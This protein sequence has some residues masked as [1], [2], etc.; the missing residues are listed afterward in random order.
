MD[1]AIFN[2]QAVDLRAVIDHCR[3]EEN[4]RAVHI[5]VNGERTKITCASIIFKNDH[6]R[7]IDA[8]ASQVADGYEVGQ[9]D[10][11]IVKRG[12]HLFLV[13]MR[14]SST[15]QPHGRHARRVDIAHS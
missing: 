8:V 6:C 9:L 10:M 12:V 11:S 7:F 2:F 15:A 14:H 5:C 1:F 4:R 3:G 13:D